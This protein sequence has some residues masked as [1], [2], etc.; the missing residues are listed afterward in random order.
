ME[1][2]ADSGSRFPTNW[3]TA[4]HSGSRPRSGSI[5]PTSLSSPSSVKAITVLRARHQTENVDGV[6]VLFPHGWGLV[7]G[8]QHA[9]RA[10]HAF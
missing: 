3:P 6:R 8:F 7:R 2:V 9:A 10:G 4:V 1:I 5:V